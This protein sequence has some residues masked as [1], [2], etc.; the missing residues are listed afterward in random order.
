MTT[1]DTWEP[2]RSK[3]KDERGAY[4]TQ[5]LFL[6]VGYDVDKAIYTFADEDKEYKGIT[7]KSLRK[8]YL[9]E[10]DPTEYHF[11]VKYLWGW[12]H[13]QRICS[14]KLLLAEV[15]KWR[16]ELEVKLRAI[17]VRNILTLAHDG[18]SA[19][20]WVADGQWDTVRDK[21]SKAGKA[22][23]KAVREAVGKEV[24]NDSARI[25]HLLPGKAK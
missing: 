1:N 15:E 7:Y 4:I 2:D 8:L 5:S 9:Q 6:E 21:R 10:A 11:A 12:E 20:K 17:G 3:F 13:W 23:E 18:M 19:A 25:L 24:S 14:N 16:E 22:K